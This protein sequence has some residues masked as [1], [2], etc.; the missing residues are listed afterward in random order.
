MLE[1]L[2]QV[3]FLLYAL[4]FIAFLNILTMLITEIAIFI[5]RKR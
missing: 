4:A 2:F 3:A 1:S 5:A